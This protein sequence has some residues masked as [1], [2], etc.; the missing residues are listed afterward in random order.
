MLRKNIVGLLICI[1]AVGVA[2]LSFAGIPDIDRCS[3]ETLALTAAPVN[4][5]N[6]PDGTGYLMT[7]ARAFDT[8]AGTWQDATITVTL[9]D[10]TGATGN[11]VFAYP[12]EDIWLENNPAV[13]PAVQGDPAGLVACTNGTLA[14]ASTDINGQTTFTG[15]F[16]AGGH[17]TY[18]EVLDTGDQSY[19]MV[20]GQPIADALDILFNS[21]DI[22]GDG[23]WSSGV[24]VILFSQRYPAS[25][26][27]SY[28]VDFYFDE[29]NDLSDLVLFSAARNVTC[30]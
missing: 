19:V 23:L 3:A 11:P 15:P 7:E 28:S 12:F 8:P 25:A 2:S 20:S 6:T 5:F 4:V 18:D 9:L 13:P 17:V 26:G 1:A 14:D 16:Y 29:V 22:D 27:Y 21:A 30:P 24:D 10:G